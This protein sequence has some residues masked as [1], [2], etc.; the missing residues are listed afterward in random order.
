MNNKSRRRVVP[1]DVMLKMAKNFEYLQP[2]EVNKWDSIKIV[3]NIDNV[4]SQDVMIKKE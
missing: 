1:D 2:N 4:F 3:R